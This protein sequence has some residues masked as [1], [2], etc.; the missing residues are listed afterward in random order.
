MCASAGSNASERDS[1][2][3]HAQGDAEGIAHEH[4]IVHVAGGQ[5]LDDL[6]RLERINFGFLLRS[7]LGEERGVDIFPVRDGRFRDPAPEVLDDYL[8]AA[9]PFGALVV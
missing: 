9:L 1:T 6:L 5:L 8:A 7:D 3:E 2:A 4:H